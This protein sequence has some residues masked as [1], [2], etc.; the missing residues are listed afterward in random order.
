M[1]HKV[2]IGIGSNVSKEKNIKSC[3]VELRKV[4]ENIIL[5]PVYETS[6]MGFDGPNFYNLVSSFDTTLSIYDLKANLNSIENDHGRHFNETKFSSRT[7]DIDILYYDNQVISNEKIKIPRK[8]IIEYDFV[9]TPL[10]DIAPNF[11]HP[12]LKISHTHI[13]ESTAIEKQ[14]ISKIDFDL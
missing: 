6:S 4:Y 3:I 11:I 8:E 7:L 9:L 13:M 1:M 5:S 10:I 14:I 12:V 2:Y